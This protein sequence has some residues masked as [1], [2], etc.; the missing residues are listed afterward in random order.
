[1]KASKIKNYRDALKKANDERVL[2]ALKEFSEKHE[3][4]SKAE[5]GKA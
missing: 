1:M 5:D 3:A 4:E 2:Q